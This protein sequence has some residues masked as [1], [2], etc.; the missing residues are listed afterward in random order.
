MESSI[1]ERGIL[2]ASWR[3][4]LACHIFGGFLSH[5]RHCERHGEGHPDPQWAQEPLWYAGNGGYGHKVGL[6]PR[7]VVE[8]AHIRG[9]FTQRT[10]WE[11]C[12]GNMKHRRH[13]VVQGELKL[14][15][16]LDPQATQL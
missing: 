7:K 2:K 15:P 14:L 10:G 11:S 4:S 3:D 1:R 9:I 12:T 13:H 5:D 8:G 6:H 16:R